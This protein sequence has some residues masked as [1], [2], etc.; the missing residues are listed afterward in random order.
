MEK[1]SKVDEAAKTLETIINQS[2]PNDNEKSLNDAIEI[3]ESMNV[4]Y[5][6]KQSKDPAP[7]PK[8]DPKYKE[9]Y[10]FVTVGDESHA[11]HPE[12]LIHV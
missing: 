1:H 9:L 6:K 10:D 7:V 2:N 11:S 8:H 5:L 3:I 4:E 12:N